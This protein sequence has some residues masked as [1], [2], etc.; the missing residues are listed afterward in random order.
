MGKKGPGSKGYKWA[1]TPGGQPG[2]KKK[3][4]KPAGPKWPTAS[5]TGASKPKG[6]KYNDRLVISSTFFGKIILFLGLK[7]LDVYDDF[8]KS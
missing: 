3:V 2:A 8:S 4:S 7:I 6:S 1:D 5:P